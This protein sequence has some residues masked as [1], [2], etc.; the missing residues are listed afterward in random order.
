MEL[1]IF[2]RFRAREGQEAELA[3][4]LANQM[5][6]VRTEP[7]CLM[8]DAY[9]STRDPRLFFIHSR[10]IDEAAFEAHAVLPNTVRFIER[11]ESLIEHP[12]NVTRSR[13]LG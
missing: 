7:G 13:P 10:W 3:A 9:R 1:F 2:A 8:I 6:F 4:L 5:P 11:A 12:L